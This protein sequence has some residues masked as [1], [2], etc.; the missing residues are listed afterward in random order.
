MPATLLKIEFR[1]VTVLDD[2]TWG[3]ADWK[4]NAEVD[5]ITV[6]DPS[7]VFEVSTGDTVNLI[8]WSLEHDVASA[9]PGETVHITFE[10]TEIG[11]VWNT[12][13]GIVQLHLHYPFED[14]VD[15]HLDGSE[16]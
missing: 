6:G 9:V 15:I 16:E 7:A 4:L 13:K 12:V 5:G 2:D 10:V 14:D 11:V 3:A 1:S 8:D